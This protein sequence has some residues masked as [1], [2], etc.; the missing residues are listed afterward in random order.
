MGRVEGL[1]SFAGLVEL[2]LHAP[3]RGLGQG[4]GVGEGDVVDDGGDF[5]LGLGV[6]LGFS[7]HGQMFIIIRN[8]I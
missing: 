7:F 1:C 2:F 8:K 5:L 6:E 3:A 4:E